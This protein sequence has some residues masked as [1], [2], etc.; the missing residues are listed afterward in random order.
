MRRSWAVGCFRVAATFTLHTLVQAAV[1]AQCMFSC[2]CAVLRKLLCRAVLLCAAAS[3]MRPGQ[4]WCS[5]TS[6]QHSS[7]QRATQQKPSSCTQHKVSSSL[8][9]GVILLYGGAAVWGQVCCL[10]LLNQGPTSPIT[11]IKPAPGIS[12]A[13]P[14]TNVA[15]AP[16]G[17]ANTVTSVGPAAYKG[18]DIQHNKHCVWSPFMQ[19][20]HSRQRQSR[21]HSSQMLCGWQ[22]R[23]SRCWR[24]QLCW[25]GRQTSS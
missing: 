3:W 10:G 13:L 20:A 6:R 1:Q 17:W 18:H 11:L 2:C 23:L 25:R 5:T 14:G 9:V 16:A 24:M 19:M 7:G 22:Q 15:C 8:R 4:T 12:L 21:C